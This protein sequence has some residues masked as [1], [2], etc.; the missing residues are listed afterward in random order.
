M[1]QASLTRCN[2]PV[3]ANEDE[4]KQIQR[5]SNNYYTIITIILP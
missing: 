4:W 1:M 5:N 2:L 3:S